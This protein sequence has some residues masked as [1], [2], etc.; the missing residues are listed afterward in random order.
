MRHPVSRYKSVFNWWLSGKN[1]AWG[2]KLYKQPYHINRVFH[3]YIVLEELSKLKNIMWI[4]TE[5][6]AEDMLQLKIDIDK[7]PQFIQSY[8]K[9][10]L[11]NNFSHQMECKIDFEIKGRKMNE[12]SEFDINLLEEK[13]IDYCYKKY[14]FIYDKHGYEKY[15]EIYKPTIYEPQTI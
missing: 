8:E 4:R 3:D 2:V 6:I 5:N 15:P 10:F 9:Y 14:R 13:H 1:P 11:N 7:Y 12:E